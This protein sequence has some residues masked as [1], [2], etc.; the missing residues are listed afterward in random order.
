MIQ[1]E[2][3]PG[4]PLFRAVNAIAEA[5]EDEFPHALVQ[6]LAYEWSRF[7]PRTR[8]RKNVIIELCDIEANFGAPLS[9]PSNAGFQRTIAGWQALTSGPDSGSLHI[10]NYVS[11]FSMPHVGCDA[12]FHDPVSCGMFIQPFPNYYVLGKNINFFHRMGVTGL[13]EQGDDS[14]AGGDMNALKNFV[15]ARLMWDPSLNPSTLIESFLR[16]YYYSAAPHV[17]EYMD[18]M[19]HAVQETKF[20]MN[21]GIPS[22]APIYTPANLLGCARAMAAAVTAARSE[23][24]RVQMRV[25]AAKVS[26]YYIVLVH[27]QAVTAFAGGDWPLENTKEAAWQEFTRVWNETGM[28]VGSAF[29]CDL[30]CVRAQLFGPHSGRHRLK[31]DEVAT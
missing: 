28:T 30:G 9:D 14:S 3:S 11:S 26:T 7:P 23:P 10:W 27:W 2:G 5:I 8:P 19:H 20:Y 16:G 18:L 6:T 21:A 31:L 25:D 4:G 15:M 29:N 22:N 24:R 13:F 17:R 12:A 1:E